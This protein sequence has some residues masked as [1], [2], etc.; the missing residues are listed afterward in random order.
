MTVTSTQVEQEAKT[1]RLEDRVLIRHL[2]AGASQ[3]RIWIPCVADDQQQQRVTGIEVD[4]LW[5]LTLHHDAE[6]GNAI[7]H[8]GAVAP[9]ATEF[10]LGVHYQMIR[11]PISLELDPAK[12]GWIAGRRE[13]FLRFL[14]PEQHV[15]VDEDMRRRAQEIMQGTEN[16][17]L[18]AK[19]LYDL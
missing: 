15:R 11:Q 7:L 5:P 19:G 6:F 14:L 8:G 2:L 4:S 1:Y 9:F 18:Q 13:P 17:L 10:S 12:A 3:M 16:A